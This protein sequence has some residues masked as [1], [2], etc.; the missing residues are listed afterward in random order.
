MSIDKT[1]VSCVLG[2]GHVS[3]R[4][5]ISFHH[6]AKQ[7]EYLQYKLGIMAAHG[8]SFRM[9]EYGAVS[10]GEFRDFVKAEGYASE[11][12]KGLREIIYPEGFKAVPEEFA[13]QFT[14]L[15]WAI[16]YMDDGRQNVMKHTNNIINGERVRIE[17]E[18]FVNRYEIDTQAFSER[19]VQILISN[20]SS[21]G[22]EARA[23]KKGRI[24]ISRAKSKANFYLGVS[25]HIHSSMQYKISA[26][27]S[28]SFNSR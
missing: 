14:F 2:D 4:G 17:T 10:Y 23:D 28:L 26:T 19:G 22:V 11:E 18:P 9:H 12:S 7:K 27:P 15:E 8:F 24:C 3:K 25:P 16:L 20:L 5:R 1:V 21:L 13:K 6:S